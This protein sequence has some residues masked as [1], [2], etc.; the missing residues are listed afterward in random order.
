INQTAI[1]STVFLCYE[2]II[3]DSIK[4]VARAKKVKITNR[5]DV[6]M[7]G[8]KIDKDKNVSIDEILMKNSDFKPF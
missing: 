2:T 5:R 7:R 4:D 8:V 3:V 1:G 6:I